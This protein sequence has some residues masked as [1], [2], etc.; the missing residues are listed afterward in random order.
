MSTKVGKP[1]YKVVLV[2]PFYNERLYIEGT[3]RSLLNQSLTVENAANKFDWHIIFINNASTDLTREYIVNYL[4]DSEISYE[5]ISETRKGTVYS[6]PTGLNRAAAMASD[7]IVSTDADTILP[8]DFIAST[9]KELMQSGADVLV[10]ARIEDKRISLWKRIVSRRL[11]QARRRIWNFEYKYFGPYFF[12]SFFAIRS[13]F[14]RGIRLFNPEESE[15]Y[16]G[17]DISLSR[18]CY[19]QGARFIKS[20]VAVWPSE[21]RIFAEKSSSFR[22]IVGNIG[23]DYDSINNMAELHFEKMNRNRENEILSEL[24]ELEARRF[25]WS[26]ADAYVFWR[27]TGRK[28]TIPKQCFDNSVRLLGK[29][30]LNTVIGYTK[31]NDCN[32]VQGF[33]FA[34]SE[35]CINR[36]KQVISRY[37]NE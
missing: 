28:F 11:F 26:L 36:V 37:I 22:T 4:K 17:E 31:H 10:G 6:R 29:D 8:Q 7:V 5:I 18:R 16:M 24:V 21:R 13:V 34:I 33:Y 30:C 2:V 14:F 3:L 27:L 1:H 19:Y 35:T 20:E 15:Q 9:Y 12:G 23:H 25:L 32:N